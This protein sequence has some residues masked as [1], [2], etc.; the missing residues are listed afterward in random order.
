MKVREVLD[1]LK[2]DGYLDANEIYAYGQTATRGGFSGAIVRPVYLTAVCGERVTMFESNPQNE[3]VKILFTAPAASL[4]D[5]RVQ[6]GFFGL[7]RKVTFT[8]NAVPYRIVTPAGARKFNGFF[9]A[10]EK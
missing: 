7:Q 10:L 9:K 1:K 8:Y 4:K 2:E 3:A 5:V 6:W